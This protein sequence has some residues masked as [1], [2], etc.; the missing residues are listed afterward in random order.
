MQQPSPA[1]VRAELARI[2]ASKYFAQ[3]DRASQFLR[4]VVE[5][6]LEGRGS[7]IKGYT[8]AIDVF[9]KPSDFDAEHDPLVRVEAGRL[10]SRLAEYYVA[11]GRDDPVRI[12]IPRGGYAP[13]FRRQ[14]ESTKEPSWGA[15]E[16]A[17]RSGSAVPLIAIAAGVLLLVGVLLSTGMNTARLDA[18][19]VRGTLAGQDA[20]RLLVLP[21]VNASIDPALDLFGY[22]MTEEIILRL[23]ESGIAVITSHV[24]VLEDDQVSM[25]AELR[26]ELVFGY[27]LTGTIRGGD[28]DS[29]RI[30]ARLVDSITGEQLWSEAYDR[31]PGVDLEEIQSDVAQQVAATISLPYGPIHAH[32]A[33]LGEQLDAE[34]HSGNRCVSRR[35]AL[36]S[37]PEPA[38]RSALVACFEAAVEAEPD[39]ADAWA[40]LAQ[41]LISS[42]RYMSDPGDTALLERGHE[43][44][45]RALDLDGSSRLGHTAML[46]AR[47]YAGDMV[48]FEASAARLLEL[49]PNS[50]DAL[51]A[52]GFLLVS[53]DQAERG[54][55]L[56]DRAIEL[57]WRPPAYLF[58]PYAIHYLRTGDYAESVAWGLRVDAPHWYVGPLF[59]AAAAGLG[60]DRERALRACIRLLELYPTFPAVARAE[61]A[62][63][64]F[65]AELIDRILRGLE[66]AGIELG[67]AD[68]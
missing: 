6:S 4:Y 25:L 19:A 40:G 9:G 49:A 44:A 33:Q 38:A 60:G 46:R 21:F 52:I 32:E 24:G 1:E 42:Y 13:R 45:R 63:W 16:R 68:Q 34:G 28:G 66:L 22:G 14:A 50:P 27:A 37:Q 62:K 35:Y 29:I 12:E 61:L 53:A 64:Q 23:S 10:R 58:V 17:L 30:T 5:A 65:E 54:L 57:S 43:A 39:S 67:S 48:G 11:V 15:R 18:D 47:F 36:S 26:D 7:S 3:A 8:I 55:P 31:E 56:L 2:L 41:A 20:P 51:G 59:V